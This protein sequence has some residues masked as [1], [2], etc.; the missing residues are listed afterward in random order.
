MNESGL[1]RFY[2]YRDSFKEDN[3]WVDVPKTGKI[4]L[5]RAHVLAD[6]FFKV[7]F[8]NITDPYNMEPTPEPEF[9]DITSPIDVPSL[10]ERPAE[11]VFNIPCDEAP[12]LEALSTPATRNFEYIQPLAVES[13]GDAIVSQHSSNNLNFILNPTGPE[14]GI[15]M[16]GGL[17]L[18]LS[19]TI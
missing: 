10:R 19:W 16:F 18:I 9:P 15:S 1:G 11:S 12:G 5:L 8:H 2:A 13:P 17:A 3:V 14:G 6:F 7:T 4:Q